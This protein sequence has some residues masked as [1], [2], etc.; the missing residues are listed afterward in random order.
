[1][2]VFGVVPIG[3]ANQSRRH[4]SR[5]HHS[6]KGNRQCVVDEL[7]ALVIQMIVFLTLKQLLTNLAMVEE[8]FE[9]EAIWERLEIKVQMVG[10]ECLDLNT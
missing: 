4:H 8:G 6:L 3:G 10:M 2:V 5:R 9:W 7:L 1:M